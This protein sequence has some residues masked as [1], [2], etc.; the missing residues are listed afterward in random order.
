M[1][2]YPCK[3]LVDDVGMKWCKLDPY[4]FWNMVDEVVALVLIMH[5][6]GILVGE[7]K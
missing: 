3:T 4:V 2:V 7:G 6:D 1:V 5:V